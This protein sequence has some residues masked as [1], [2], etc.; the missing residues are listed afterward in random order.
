MLVPSL[1]E[2]K[3]I[4][5]QGIYKKIPV[6]AEMYADMVTPMQ[7]V[8]ILKNITKH[9]FLLESAEETK[10]WGRYTF[11]GYD[12]ALE[13]TCQ[14]GHLCIKSGTEYTEETQEPQK[15]LRRIL[16]EN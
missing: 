16:A 6:R 5:E 2:V 13:V 14:N 12:P 4:A 15:V 11:I 8:R 10:R 1:E 7:V 9:I 3:Q